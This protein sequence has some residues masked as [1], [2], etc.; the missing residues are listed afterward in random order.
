MKAGRLK[1]RINI[2][3]EEITPGV[4]GYEKLK[5][6]GSFWCEI[7]TISG[8]EYQ[9]LGSNANEL[10]H[11]IT[12]RF[13]NNINAEQIGLY[14]NRKFRFKVVQNPGE[15]NRELHIIAVEDV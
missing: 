10:T 14:G 6:V 3:D 5:L 1:R 9:N 12:M 7:N 15:R 11:K 13:H 2:Y 8:K 4:S